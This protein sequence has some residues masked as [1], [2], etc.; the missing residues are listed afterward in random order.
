MPGEKFVSIQIQVVESQRFSQ[1][2]YVLWRKSNSEAFV[3]DPGFDTD[4]ILQLLRKHSLTL[5]AIVLT[6]GHIDHIAGNAAMKAAFPDAPIII[7]VNDAEM[8]TDPMLNLSGAY[9][10]PLV[11]PA[12]DRLVVEGDQLTVAGIELEVFD[13]P[14]HSPG[15]VV[16]LV[17]ETTPMLV[18]GGDVLF[19][20]SIGRTD[21][22]GGSFD[23]LATGILTK[24]W[25]LPDATQ[26]FPGH[27]P[28]TTI[29]IER[30]TNPFVG[31]TG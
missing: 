26:V 31:G 21:F 15:H 5:T 1:N 3:I 8:L 4:R 23:Q 22:P 24:L 29:G 9:G 25:P 6:H 7:G 16:Y 30:E 28:M 14:G 19:Q 13:I 11:S 12:A 18:L 17:R 10:I 2:T 20:G 27:G